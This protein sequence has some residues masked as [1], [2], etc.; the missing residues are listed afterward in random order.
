MFFLDTILHGNDAVLRWVRKSDDRIKW[1]FGNRRPAGLCSRR[2]PL[3]ALL[4]PV[5]SSSDVA[6]ALVV[7][8]AVSADSSGND[9]EQSKILSDTS[10]VSLNSTIVTAAFNGFFYVESDDRSSGIRVNS[11]AT[12]CSRKPRDCRGL[13]ADRRRW[14]EVHKRHERIAERV[15]QREPVQM[16]NGFH[17]RW[18]LELRSLDQRRPVRSVGRS[19]AEQ[20]R[21]ACADLPDLFGQISSDEFTVD[22]GGLPRSC[23]CCP[24][25]SST[26]TGSTWAL[27][28]YLHARIPAG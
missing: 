10:E 13:Y 14:R 3:A 22:G 11:R 15:R 4:G 16:A 25:G 6:L 18:Q 2:F 17:R 19:R 9:I 12:R 5:L 28:E 26:P 24:A 20:H 8:S 23:A 1:Q 7:A 21:A 27:R